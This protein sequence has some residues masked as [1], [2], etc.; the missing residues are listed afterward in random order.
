MLRDGKGQPERRAGEARRLFRV[1][2]NR[3]PVLLGSQPGHDVDDQDLRLDVHGLQTLLALQQAR[4]RSG[5]RL[6]RWGDDILRLLR[7]GF[8]PGMRAA[9]QD[10][11]GTLALSRMRKMRFVRRKVPVS[12]FGRREFLQLLL[13]LHET[14]ERLQRVF[15]HAL[16]RVWPALQ[17]EE[18]LSEMF[19]VLLRSS[20]GHGEVRQV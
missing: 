15:D 4:R 3:S 11:R 16:P 8:P 9:G 6:R 14:R 2:I 7:Q 10:S 13:D 17:G 12:Y 20:E 19:Q 5:G 1:H 18:V